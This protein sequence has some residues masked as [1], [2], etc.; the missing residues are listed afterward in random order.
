MVT[1]A[2]ERIINDL[3]DEYKNRLSLTCTCNECLDDILALTLNGIKP[4]YVTNPDKV[5]YVKAEY[6]DKQQ[7][8]SLLVRLAECAKFVSDHPTCKTQTKEHDP[9]SLPNLS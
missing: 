3:L 4:R 2:M 8:T 7:M 1:N 6:F 5:M 9:Y